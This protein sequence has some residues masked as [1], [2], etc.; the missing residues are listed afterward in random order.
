MAYATA[1]ARP[2]MHGR[3]G[4]PAGRMRSDRSKEDGRVVHRARGAL[5]RSPFVM[6]TDGGNSFPGR[7]SGKSRKGRPDNCSISHS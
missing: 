5:P 6:K 1:P 2:L 7:S 3:G 4:S